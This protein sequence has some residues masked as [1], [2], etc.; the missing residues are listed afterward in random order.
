MAGFLDGFAQSFNPSMQNSIDR[1][2]R[3]QNLDKEMALREAQDKRQAEEHDVRLSGLRTAQARDNQYYDEV[4]NAVDNQQLGVK[5]VGGTARAQATAGLQAIDYNSPSG[6][7]DAAPAAPVVRGEKAKLGTT[8]RAIG[9]A[10]LRTGK[11]NADQ[12]GAVEKGAK[13]ADYTDSYKEYTDEWRKMSP[14]ERD[15]VIEEQSKADM[16]RGYG[17]MERMGKTEY[18]HYVAPGKAPV[19]LNTK[20]AEQI[21]VLGRL[22]EVDPQRA[23]EE[24]DKLTGKLQGVAKDM[25]GAQVQGAQATNQAVHNMNTDAYHQSQLGILRDKTANKQMPPEILKELSDLEIQHVNA[26]TTKDKADIERQYQMVLSRAGA[27]VGRPMGLPASK[28]PPE[29]KFQANTNGKSFYTNAQG[30]PVAGHD[31]TVGMVPFGP[32]PMQDKGMA[33]QLQKSGVQVM[34]VAT[35]TGVVWGF[36]APGSNEPFDNA[37]EAIASTQ[38]SKAGAGRGVVAPPRP[39]TRSEPVPAGGIRRNGP[40]GAGVARLPWE[41]P[42]GS[43]EE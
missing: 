3:Q 29:F 35:D 24:I 33:R 31:D 12:Y 6:A 8:M 20:E 1:Y 2:M 28:V 14:K 21:Y 32:N 26:K 22:R 16:I 36:F 19:K 37:A 5:D 27:A 9:A 40:V 13:D 15:A 4:G 10:G 30:Q 41:A 7:Y 18:L 42:T 11:I 43:W 39:S 38:G 34:P 25:F 23:S 17:S